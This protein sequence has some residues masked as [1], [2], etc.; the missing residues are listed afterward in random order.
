[1]FFKQINALL[2]QGLHDIA[3]VLLLILGKDQAI[4]ALERLALL[5]LRDFMLP[6]MAG[7]LVHLQLLPILI[8]REDPLLAQFLIKA[9]ISDP[10]FAVSW[11]LTWF[12]HNLNNLESAS[13]MLDLFLASNPIMPV[14]V[15]VIMVLQRRDEVMALPADD[16][17][18]IHGT[19]QT[20]PP[21]DASA[22]DIIIMEASELFG[23]NPPEQFQKRAASITWNTDPSSCV[24]LYESDV[25]R[26]R[27]L[28][29]HSTKLRCELEAV[30]TQ[31]AKN[32]EQNDASVSSRFPAPP[33]R[34]FRLK[35]LQQLPSRQVVAWGATTAVTIITAILSWWIMQNAEY[36]RHA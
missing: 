21:L 18:L 7:T 23:R 27:R 33:T 25:V 19:L 20:L 16:I 22:L 28:R 35:M 10:F 32:L 15:A 29:L 9:G 12:A 36:T 24:T 11:V 3:G 30:Q 31:F 14:Y 4:V 34:L 6:T 1:M 13:R 2:L 26:E 17:A 5:F 8:Q